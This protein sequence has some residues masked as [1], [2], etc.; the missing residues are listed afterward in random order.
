MWIR[1][2]REKTS[3]EKIQAPEIPEIHSYPTLSI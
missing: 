1:R 3:R 2:I